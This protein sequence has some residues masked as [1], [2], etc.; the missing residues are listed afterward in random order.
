MLRLAQ[1]G[2]DLEVA[3]EGL[4]GLTFVLELLAQ[5]VVVALQVV[6]RKEFDLGFRND[7]RVL[8]SL[9]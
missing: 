7:N 4:D 5:H 8:F 1:F 2:E 6:E 9:S 3:L